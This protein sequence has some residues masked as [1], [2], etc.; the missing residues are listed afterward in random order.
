M[1]SFGSLGPGSARP[2]RTSPQATTGQGPC[3]SPGSGAPAKVGPLAEA[4][5]PGSPAGTHAHGGAPECPGDPC[6]AARP[7]LSLCRFRR[8]DSAHRVQGW[9]FGPMRTID[10]VSVVRISTYVNSFYYTSAR[11]PGCS[12]WIGAASCAN[13][14]ASGKR[15]DRARSRQVARRRIVRARSGPCGRRTG[16]TPRGSSCGTPAPLP[17]HR[18]PADPVRP[19]GPPAFPVPARR[20]VAARHRA[21]VARSA[22]ASRPRRWRRARAARQ[23]LPAARQRWSADPRRDGMVLGGYQRCTVMGQPAAVACS[24]P[25][26]LFGCDRTVSYITSRCR[27]QR[28]HAQFGGQPLGLSAGSAKPRSRCRSFPLT[29]SAGRRTFGSVCSAAISKLLPKPPSGRRP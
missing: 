1:V 25:T 7:S 11:V 20:A 24:S 6:R 12:A 3:R 29:C 19:R 10:E 18:A 9:R 28:V 22:S 13:R 15:L 14:T 23:L 27:A 2:D 8:P 21:E 4:C 17:A 16:P 26:S 5:A